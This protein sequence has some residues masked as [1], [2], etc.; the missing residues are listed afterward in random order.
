MEGDEGK[1]WVVL[2]KRKHFHKW[3]KVWISKKTQVICQILCLACATPFASKSNLVQHVSAE[4]HFTEDQS[5]VAEV[6]RSS[7]I[8]VHT[9]VWTKCSE[10]GNPVRWQDSLSWQQLE[11]Q[12]WESTVRAPSIQAGD[13]ST[14]HIQIFDSLG[15]WTRPEFNIDRYFISVCFRN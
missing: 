13:N 10:Q 11:R 3:K 5:E 2:R 4:A 1:E 8:Q 6:F 15:A 12:E 9:Q 7:E 14:I